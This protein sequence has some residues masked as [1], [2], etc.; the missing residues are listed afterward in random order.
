M[1][2]KK[3]PDYMDIRTSAEKALQ[4]SSAAMTASVILI[5]YH[6]GDAVIVF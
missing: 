3:S 6:D 5:A 4:T 1:Q 2:P